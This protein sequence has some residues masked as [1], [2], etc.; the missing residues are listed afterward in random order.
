MKNHLTFQN[1]KE[2]LSI[3]TPAEQLGIHQKYVMRCAT[4]KP[5]MRMF[6]ALLVLRDLTVQDFFFTFFKAVMEQDP[7][8]LGLIEDAYKIKNDKEISRITSPDKENIY[9]LIEEYSPFNSGGSGEEEYD[10]TEWGPR[11]KRDR[12]KVNRELC[13]R[14]SKE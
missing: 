5:Q 4:T 9:E 12:K 2:G 13:S 14:D 6:K 11:N 1:K 8:I 10:E 7:K 3:Q